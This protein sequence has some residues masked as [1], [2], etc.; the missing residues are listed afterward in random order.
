MIRPKFSGKVLT[1]GVPGFLQRSSTGFGNAQVFWLLAENSTF[2]LF[3]L[4]LANRLCIRV[5]LQIVG[6][7]S[8]EYPVEKEGI[9]SFPGGYGQNT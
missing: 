3:C 6:G 2:Y 5:C 8:I 1:A 7:W 4:I 9:W